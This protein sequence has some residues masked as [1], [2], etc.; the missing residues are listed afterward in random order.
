[1]IVNGSSLEIENITSS[2]VSIFNI[3]LNLIT[4]KKMKVT[5]IIPDF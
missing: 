5:E 3:D 1:M 4:K 2:F